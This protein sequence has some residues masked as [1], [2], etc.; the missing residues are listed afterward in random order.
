MNKVEPKHIHLCKPNLLRKRL[1]MYTRQLKPNPKSPL[2]CLP[3]SNIG[4]AA[5]SGTTNNNSSLTKGNKGKHM[6]MVDQAEERVHADCWMTWNS[7]IDY[8]NNYLKFTTSRSPTVTA[9]RD[10]SFGWPTTW[11]RPY[12]LRICIPIIPA[13]TISKY[14]KCNWK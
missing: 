1:H 7:T 5:K 9:F 13:F 11:N 3:R 6:D 2:H 8:S 12:W 14:Q 4:A 10:I